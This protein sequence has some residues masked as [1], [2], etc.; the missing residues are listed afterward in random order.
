MDLVL[1]TRLHGLV[2]AIKHRVPV[3]AV[4]PVPGGG[5]LTRQA[6]T[7]GWPLVV[8]ADADEAD[9]ERAFDFCLTDEARREA[10]RC[11]QAALEALGEVRHGFIEAFGSPPGDDWGDGRRRRVW[12]HED[13]R[14]TG[15]GRGW[16][17]RLSERL[18]AA[19][20]RRQ[21]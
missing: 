18:S 16:G 7:I 21:R 20:R 15:P 17:Q 5:K 9:L 8:A 10:A 2:L 14:V 6:E 11:R 19:L 1:T 4:D 13:P 12:L 3:V